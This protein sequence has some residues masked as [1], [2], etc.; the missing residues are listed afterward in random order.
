MVSEAPEGWT[1]DRTGSHLALDFANTVSG[2]SS[3]APIERLPYYADLLEFARQTN[4]LREPDVRA[5]EAK[6][7]KHAPRAEKTNVRARA[8]RDALFGIFTALAHKWRPALG[9]IAVLNEHVGR[10]FLD[11]ELNWAY[12]TSG[13]EGLETVLGPIVLAA[14]E[15]IETPQRDRVRICGSD[16]CQ[17]LFLDTTKSGTR[18]WCEMKTCGNREKA[19]RFREGA[20]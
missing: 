18:R 5:L 15:L 8:L 16:T 19:R 20:Q 17:F 12:E 11:A 7:K 4:I 6:A 14:L 9:D 2:R 13:D 1:F 10:V 3:P